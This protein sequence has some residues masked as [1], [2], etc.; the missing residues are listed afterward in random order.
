MLNS[1]GA[2]FIFK[3]MSLDLRE[4]NDEEKNFYFKVKNNDIK[5]INKNNKKKENKKEFTKFNPKKEI[6]KEKAMK[7]TVKQNDNVDNN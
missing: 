1:D 3:D 4:P 2:L 6:Y 7:I 5:K